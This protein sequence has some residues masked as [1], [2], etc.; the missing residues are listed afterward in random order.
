MDPVITPDERPDA[1]DREKFREMLESKP[2]AA[3]LRRVKNELDRQ[4]HDCR[5]ADEIGAVRY[6]Q[7]CSW[8]A[9]WVLNLPLQMLAE[10]AKVADAKKR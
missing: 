6:A 2:F 5:T 1:I 4:I 3:F 7:G 9:E 8:V 10:M